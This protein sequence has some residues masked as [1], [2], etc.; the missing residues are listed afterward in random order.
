MN[1]TIS[2]PKPLSTNILPNQGKQ[3]TYYKC[4]KGEP[5]RMSNNKETVRIAF[6]KVCLAI[7]QLETV[8]TRLADLHYVAEEVEIS[9]EILDKVSSAVEPSS[10][11]H[12]VLYS[13]NAKAQEALRERL[14]IENKQVIS[15]CLGTAYNATSEAFLSIQKV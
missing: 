8:K 11:A 3:L 5:N 10:D 15:S 6:D 1:N 13:R 12:E 14:S 7:S 9:Q 4:V 2:N